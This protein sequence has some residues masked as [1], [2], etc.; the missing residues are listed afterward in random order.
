MRVVR[1]SVKRGN[2]AMAGWTLLGERQG[3]VRGYTGTKYSVLVYWP[4]ECGPR[5]ERWFEHLWA[6]CGGDQTRPGLNDGNAA[7]CS[8]GAELRARR[9]DGQRPYA[10][11]A[12]H[13]LW[14]AVCQSEYPV[15]V[16][17]AYSPLQC[18]RVRLLPAYSPLP[19]DTSV[20]AVAASSL[21]PDLQDTKTGPALRAGPVPL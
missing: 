4:P 6:P 21:A 18:R 10:R 15:L 1:R 2:S 16:L 9:C 3:R 17:P 13:E 7:R 20:L 19:S 12:L 11:T 8:L 14:G 5:F